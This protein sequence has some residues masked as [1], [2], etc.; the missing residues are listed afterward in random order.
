MFTRGRK[1]RLRMRSLVISNRPGH[2]DCSAQTA[3]FFQRRYRRYVTA[4]VQDL[5]A[6]L[7]RGACVGVTKRAYGVESESAQ[8]KLF[9]D[10]KKFPDQVSRRRHTTG[11][12]S[13][14]VSAPQNAQR[15]CPGDVRRHRHSRV[16][17]VVLRRQYR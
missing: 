6:H 4:W 17:V 2:S 13:D 7:A 12:T 14:A 1:A 16:N 5:L 10:S 11:L 9:P 3:H 8:Q 15:Q